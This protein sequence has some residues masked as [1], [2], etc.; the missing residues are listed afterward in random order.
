MSNSNPEYWRRKLSAFLHDR[1]DKVISLL[2]H[3]GRALRE[4]L[5]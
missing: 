4:T 3:E 1:P 2:D 5:N